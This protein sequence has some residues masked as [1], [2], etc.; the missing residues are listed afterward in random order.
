MKKK[1]KRENNISIAILFKREKKK[2]QKEEKKII[3]NF[4]ANSLCSS[5]SRILLYMPAMYKIARRSLAFAKKV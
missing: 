4:N 1:K 2:R 5:I 3:S